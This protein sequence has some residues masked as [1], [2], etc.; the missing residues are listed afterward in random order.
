MPFYYLHLLAYNV[1]A[2]AV[3]RGSSIMKKAQRPLRCPFSSISPQGYCPHDGATQ[4]VS[5]PIS[6]TCMSITKRKQFYWLQIGRTRLP[7]GFS[8]PTALDERKRSSCASPSKNVGVGSDYECVRELR[9]GGRGVQVLEKHR[10]YGRAQ[11]LR[12]GEDGGGVVRVF[13]EARGL[14]ACPK[15]AEAEEGVHWV[16]RKCGDYKCA[17]KLGVRACE[18]G[19]SLEKFPNVG[20]SGGWTL[21]Q[22][23]ALGGY[24]T[25]Y[26]E[27]LGTRN[28]TS[29]VNL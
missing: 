13:G 26:R 22:E 23:W 29:R 21:V 12:E 11:K 14:P 18:R 2:H 20:K 1:Q 10:D 4:T 25:V 27:A 9:E 3:L 8:Q 24:F 6:V 5:L 19:A 16:W 17:R 15:T 28:I 7:S